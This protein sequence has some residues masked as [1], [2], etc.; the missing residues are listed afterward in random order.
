MQELIPA[1]IAPG[2]SSSVKRALLIIA[3]I[4]IW[5]FFLWRAVET[6]APGSNYVFFNSDCAIPILMANDERPITISNAYYYG[7]DRWG[8]WPMLLAQAVRRTF[9]YRWTDQS[10]FIMQAVCAFAGAL[11]L[12]GLAHGRDPL[13]VMLIY[14]ITLC[15][16]G[17]VRHHLF[18]VSEVYAWQVTTLLLGWYCLRRT[19]EP[20]GPE[21]TKGKSWHLYVWCF[22]ALW[23]S[24]LAIFSSFASAPFL[25]F[26]LGLEA[27]RSHLK[28]EPRRVRLDL[29]ALK[30]YSIGFAL[31]LAATLAEILLRLNYHRYNVKHYGYDFKTSTAIDTG[32]LTE[33]LYAQ[34]HNLIQVAWWPFF[35]VSLLALLSLLCVLIYLRVKG[36]N[37]LMQTLRSKL[38][39]DI[40][41]LI[42]GT[43]GIAVI[44]FVLVVAI[45]HVRFN[46]YNERYL[47]LTHLFGSV[48]GLLTLFL[49]FDHA[50]KHFGLRSYART[51]LVAAAVVLLALRFPP[52][53]RS[54][55]YELTRETALTL[56]RK[57]PGAVLMGGYWETYVFASLQPVNTMT[58]I[59][60]EGQ[61]VRML[62]T[63]ETVRQAESVILEYRHSKFGGSQLPPPQHTVQY[64]ALF[65]LIDP[66]W[67]EDGEYAFALYRNESR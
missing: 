13:A 23:F 49:I 55:Y 38:T 34:L 36:R 2:P 11:V 24:F 29:R 64:G 45:D 43:C 67:Y 65:R 51:A 21:R 25:F 20:G 56:A 9:D 53:S 10:F 57:A 61:H 41:I 3:S 12:A 59:P 46:Q 18:E 66:L 30:R 35:A 48:S 28:A 60:Y 50:R 22:L 44:N 39:D 15:L 5:G 26:L 4:F 1:S 62:W 14:L 31:V 54:P 8:G 37:E 42:A 40:W 63:K 19:S 27:L 47:T 6:F 32:H 17:E 52:V 58:P 33:N 16:H 7:Q